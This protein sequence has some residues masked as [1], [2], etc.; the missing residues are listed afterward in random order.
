MLKRTCDICD[1]DITYKQNIISLWTQ[2]YIL[3]LRWD[4][5]YCQECVKRF[6]KAHI[7]HDYTKSL[8]LE[9]PE[10]IKQ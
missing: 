6:M 2:K 8:D 3:T 10:W 9:I 7:E 1:K 5:D 4:K